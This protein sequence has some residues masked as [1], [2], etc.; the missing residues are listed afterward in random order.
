MRFLHQISIL[1]KRYPKWWCWLDLRQAKWQTFK[2][3]L[4]IKMEG[5][6]HL[7]P[8]CNGTTLLRVRIMG[9]RGSKWWGPTWIFLKCSLKKRAIM[10]NFLFTLPLDL[11]HLYS[12]IWYPINHPQHISKVRLSKVRTHNKS[13]RTLK[14]MRISIISITRTNWCSSHSNNLTNICSTRDWVSKM[15]SNP[16]VKLINQRTTIT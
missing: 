3:Y 13:S 4:W 5:L 14:W 12:S 8:Q 9:N 11:S 7:T 2:S 15:L 16:L 1:S 10:E 6:N